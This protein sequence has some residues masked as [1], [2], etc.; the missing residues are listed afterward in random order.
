MQVRVNTLWVL[1]ALQFHDNELVRWMSFLETFWLT[2]IATVIGVYPL[3]D[4]NATWI[5]FQ[6][7]DFYTT[8]KHLELEFKS[9]K[10][11]SRMHRVHV[12]VAS[13][14]EFDGQWPP[15]FFNKTIDGKDLSVFKN[16]TRN[17]LLN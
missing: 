16:V 5:Q 17:L 3:E 13:T 14:K 7:M 10:M 11:N 4:K 15:H 1:I 9:H 8:G 6:F 2:P 12:V